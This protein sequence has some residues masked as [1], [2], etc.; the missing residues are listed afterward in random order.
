MRKTTQKSKKCTQC[1]SSHVV[2]TIME[3]G[4]IVYGISN[5]VELVMQKQ[6]E[7]AIKKLGTRPDFR[8]F[9]DYTITQYCNT[10]NNAEE[11]ENGKEYEVRF[12]K[13]LHKSSQKYQNFPLYIIEI[14]AENYG[15]PKSEIKLLTRD[16]QRQGVLIRLKDYSYKIKLVK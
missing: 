6:D 9:N 16:L 3:T 7:F 12:R 1:G 8:T 13:M 10:K 15:I 14:M 4:E 11:K 5:V 2:S